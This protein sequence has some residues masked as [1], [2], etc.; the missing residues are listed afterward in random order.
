MGVSPVAAVS[1]KHS[2]FIEG[3]IPA[4]VKGVQ[5]PGLSGWMHSSRDGIADVSKSHPLSPFW[6]HFLGAFESLKRCSRAEGS[7]DSPAAFCCSC[8][9]NNLTEKR[10]HRLRKAGCSQAVRTDPGVLQQPGAAS[11]GSPVQLHTHTGVFWQHMP[12][13]QHV[14]CCIRTPITS[15]AL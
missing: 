7:R 9:M 3:K 15:S 1:I 8:L 11:A 5:P 6:P 4:L 13:S 14:L 10:L 2:S 12:P